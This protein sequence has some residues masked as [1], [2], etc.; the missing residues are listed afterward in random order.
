MMTAALVARPAAPWSFTPVGPFRA[1]RDRAEGRD[2]AE[3]GAVAAGVTTIEEEGHGVG[4]A[5]Y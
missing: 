1:A 5:G 2:A 4:L 3:G